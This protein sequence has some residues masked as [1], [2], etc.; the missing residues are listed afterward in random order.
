MQIAVTVILTSVRLQ[1]T[2][3]RLL[4]FTDASNCLQGFADPRSLPV[5]DITQ[6]ASL[7]NVFPYG[8]H[9]F[10]NMKFQCDGSVKGLKIVLFY[11]T[12]VNDRWERVPSVELLQL[13][14]PE[15]Y[16]N[17]SDDTLNCYRLSFT[18]EH[19]L[20]NEKDEAE[21]F[22]I[23]CSDM[24]IKFRSNTVLTV[25]MN[26][27]TP[28]TVKRGDY[29][30]L[31]VPPLVMTFEDALPIV[32]TGSNYES[33]FIAIPQGS[34]IPSGELLSA[35]A[36]MQYVLLSRMSIIIRSHMHTVSIEEQRHL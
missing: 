20:G 13:L 24:C 28:M 30:G 12:D 33:P 27:S 25:S 2:Q 16:R 31:V 22:D 21:L 19:N 26:F 36:I 11:T 7:Y 18:I 5:K 4:P 17:C 9:L 32:Y 23:Q 29:L 15:N 35:N 3:V 8:L 14:S 1:V 6:N 10:P 34:F